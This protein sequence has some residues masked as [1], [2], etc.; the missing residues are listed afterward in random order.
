MSSPPNRNTPLGLELDKHGVGG[1][2]TRVAQY[3]IAG[4]LAANIGTGSAV[5]PTGTSRQI[6]AAAAADKIVGVFFG[7]QYV[8]A[9]GNTQFRPNWTSGQT[10][11]ANS[12]VEASVQDDPYAMFR[13]QVG[14]VGSAAFAGNN[15]GFLA[16]LVIGT[17]NLA[18][19]RS[20]DQLDYATITSTTPGGSGSQFL[21]DDVFTGSQ[22]PEFSGSFGLFAKAIVRCAKHYLGPTLV[23]E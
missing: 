12:L 3:Y 22:V 7:C 14:G 9:G 11:Q 17:V 18:T 6:T 10:I 2:A 19:G 13:I 4:A 1:V 16:D 8:D 15:I 23:A 21:I 20:A 5:K